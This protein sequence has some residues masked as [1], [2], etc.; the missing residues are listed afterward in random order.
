MC[1]LRAMMVETRRGFTLLETLVAFAILA[2]ALAGLIGAFG[3]G[4]GG[5]GRIEARMALTRAGENALAALGAQTPLAPG[6]REGIAD[7]LAWRA[8]IRAVDPPPPPGVP[9][10]YAVRIE[11]R[12]AAGRRMV[13]RTE[14]LGAVP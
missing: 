6:L 4:L 14:R 9:Q 5:V 7:G 2:V 11:I 3:D 10:L 13:L 1:A 8:E 12:D